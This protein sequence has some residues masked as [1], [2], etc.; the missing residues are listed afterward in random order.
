MATDLPYGYSHG[1]RL[2]AGDPSPMT[3]EESASH[4]TLLAEYQALEEEYSGHYKYPEEIDAR[5]GQ[6]EMAMEALE[7][8]PLIYDLAE[9]ARGGVFVTLDRNG[10]LAVYHGYVR[11]EDEPR[12]ETAVLDGDGADAIGQGG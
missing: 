9:V 10:S 1:L 8:R 5:L 12:E 4:A 2:L 6:L 11:P 7:Q 3:D